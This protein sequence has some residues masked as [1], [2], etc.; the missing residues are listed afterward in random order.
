MGKSVFVLLISMV[1]IQSGATAAKMLFPVVGATGATLL[2]LGL[3]TFILLI[4]WPPQKS[5]MSRMDLIAIARYGASLGCMNL[6]FYLAI[7]KIPLGIAVAVEFI[8]PLSVALFSSRKSSDFLWAILAIVGILM[9]LPV[10]PVVAGSVNYTGITFALGAGFFWALYIVFG[11]KIGNYIDGKRATA[12]G[13]LFATLAVLPVGILRADLTLISSKV[14]PWAF[15]VALLSS[16]IPYSLEMVAL[17]KMPAKT[18]GILMSLEPVL[19]AFCG[20]IFLREYLTWIQCLAIVCIIIASLGSSIS[21]RQE[22]KTKAN[23][24][25]EV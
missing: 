9:I 22:L 16:A 17:R 2:R 4:L 23:N 7:E 5:K 15:L 8:G 12:L 13:M 19:A 1:S 25:V 3:A 14:L 24:L 18:F 10:S 11:Q 21:A 6:C 20:L